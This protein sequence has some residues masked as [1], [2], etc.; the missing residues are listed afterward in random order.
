M[1]QILVDNCVFFLHHLHSTLPLIV[2]VL[3]RL[4]RGI[5]SATDMLPSLEKGARVLHIVLTA[6]P[7]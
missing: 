6:H 4:D 1:D 2:I 7:I 3:S 5:Q